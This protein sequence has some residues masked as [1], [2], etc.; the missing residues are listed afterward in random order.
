MQPKN[1]RPALGILLVVI[2]AVLLLDAA[3]LIPL[4][5]WWIAKWYT[6]LIAIGVF[7]LFTNNRTAGVILIAVGGLFLASGANLF[8]FNWNYVWPIVIIII[9]LGFLFRNKIQ[10]TE[11]INETDNFFDVV[12][13]FGGSKQAVSGASLLGGRVTSI[14]GGSEVDLRS[15]NL[16]PGAAIEVFTMFGATEILVPANWNVNVE[17][18]SIFGGF[19][20][21][22]TPISSADAPLLKIKG[23][24]ILG[25]GEV[26]S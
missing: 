4:S 22:R 20:N 6:L 25:G 1:R 21:K 2:G 8:D 19:E 14:F 10:S 17:V 16:A 12:S 24:T 13:I 5:L 11:V 23:M 7:N 18:S 26:K 9:G 3:R 15:A